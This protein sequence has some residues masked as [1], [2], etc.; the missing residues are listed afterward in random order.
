MATDKRFALQRYEKDLAWYQKQVNR[1]KEE[2]EEEEKMD[3]SRN[4]QLELFF[5]DHPKF[6]AKEVIFT[7]ER[8]RV[9]FLYEDHLLLEIIGKT[10]TIFHDLRKIAIVGED[11][12]L[13]LCHDEP[14]QSYETAN[15]INAIAKYIEFIYLVS[16]RLK[17]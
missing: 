8:I 5:K 2:I 12:Q 17:V 9:L 1:L 4:E 15:Y 13:I 11:N 3:T 10:I 7:K 16:F 14:W 6:P